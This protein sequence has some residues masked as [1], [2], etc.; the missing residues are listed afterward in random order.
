LAS[1]AL[2]Q[3]FIAQLGRQRGNAAVQRVLAADRPAVN[4]DLGRTVRRGRIQRRGL[5]GEEKPSLAPDPVEGTVSAQVPLQ[6][7]VIARAPRHRP[8]PPWDPIYQKQPKPGRKPGPTPTQH[9]D[10]PTPVN[11]GARATPENT[12]LAKAIDDLA[13]LK[14][15]DLIKRR[16]EALIGAISTTGAE[17]QRHLETLHAIEYLASQ[18][19]LPDLEYQK[20]DESGATRRGMRVSLEERVRRKGS[21]DKAMAEFEQIGVT[22]PDVGK[23]MEPHLEFFRAEQKSFATEF[24]GQAY[25]TTERML[26]E[27]RQAINEVLKSYGLPVDSASIAAQRV[28]QGSSSAEEEAPHVIKAATKSA[29]VD[30]P[31]SVKHRKGLADTV[32]VLKKHQ[33]AVKTH[34]R[35]YE[36]LLDQFRSDRSKFKPSLRD[37]N[38][39]DIE[40]SRTALRVAWIEAERRHPVLA[41]YRHGKDL[42]AVDPNVREAEIDPLAEVDLGKLDTDPVE[43]QM[44]AVVAQLLPK[45]VDIGKAKGLLKDKKDAFSLS[46]PSVVAL[47]RTN[48][49]IPK[50]SIRDGIVNDLVSDAKDDD[51]L[52]QTLALALALITLIPSGGASLAIPAAAASIGMAVYSAG[53]EWEKYK[54]Q[55]TL[56]NTSLDLA[57]SLSTEEPSLTGFALSLVNLGLEALPLVTAFKKARAIKKLANAGGDAKA[58]ER[59][60]KEAV[61]DLNLYGRKH[62]TVSDLGDRA[63]R[64]IVGDLGAVGRQARAELEKKHGKDL[65]S[66]YKHYPD[67]VT[68]PADQVDTFLTWK[69]GLS[70]DTHALFEANPPMWRTYATM[71]PRVRKV[72][73]LCHS[74]CV[75]PWAMAT[76]QSGRILGLLE[77]HG[78]DG[79]NETLRQFFHNQRTLS[80]LREALDDIEK[81]KNVDDLYR[82]MLTSSF[83]RTQARMR[84]PASLVRMIEESDEQYVKRLRELLGK[85]SDH[86]RRQQIEQRLEA[87]EKRLK[88]SQQS[89]SPRSG[90]TIPKSDIPTLK[91]GKLVSNNDPAKMLDSEL[92]QLKEYYGARKSQGNYKSHADHIDQEIERRRIEREDIPKARE[93]FKEQAKKR[94]SDEDIVMDVLQNSRE[95]IWVGSKEQAQR[96]FNTLDEMGESGAVITKQPAKSADDLPFRGPERHI[97]AEKGSSLIH[98]NAEIIHNGKRINIHIYFPPK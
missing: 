14:V 79:N 23:Q 82:R 27:S 66:L 86:L 58:A 69:K 35:T 45:M 88:A 63:R 8:R 95:H 94:A 22:R 55:K 49:F 92:E 46:L 48:M 1:P 20:A 64:E 71:D 50:G 11:A 78:L 90:A 3:Q 18:R 2:R 42:G 56:V 38:E 26:T 60:L 21:F 83:E 37:Q 25:L 24:K 31:A 61:D 44:E 39:R 93:H 36:E 10:P 52:I 70:T 19:D 68:L 12:G 43:R 30:A 7:Q 73:T 33:E 57:R 77:R 47:T 91:G 54:T 97:G 76:E 32:E 96:I 6:R 5:A 72:L 16:E 53:Q 15:P 4:A 89:L 81:A 51:G 17:Q 74:P 13:L 34:W 29:D 65:I 75:P 62:S 87:A 9:D 59:A 98:Y 67:A 84:D 80:S 41:A 85:R 40:E 28:A